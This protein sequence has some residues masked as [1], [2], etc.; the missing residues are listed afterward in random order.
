M[1]PTKLIKDNLDMFLDSLTNIVNILLENGIFA[2]Q[3]KQLSFGH[4]WK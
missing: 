1:L 3:W 4:F 2:E